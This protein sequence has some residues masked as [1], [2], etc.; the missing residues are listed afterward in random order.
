MI[1]YLALIT[2]IAISAISGYYSIVG[3]ATIF[4][5]AYWSV[6]MMGAALELGKLVTASWLYRNW[7]IAPSL[8]KIYLTCAV[9]LLMFI[10]SMGIFGFLSKAHMQ[11]SVGQN[12]NTDQ[13][14]II[15]QKIQFEKEKIDDSKKVLSQLDGAIDKLMSSDRLRGKDGAI[16][17]RNNQ[18]AEREQLMKDIEQSSSQ[19]QKFKLEVAEMS[20]AQRK[21]ELEVGPLKYIAELIYG[22]EAK[23]HFENAVRWVIILLVCV[24]DPLA[25]VLLVAANISLGYNRRMTVNKH[26]D[27]IEIDKKVLKT[28]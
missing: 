11:Q 25:V 2:A 8:L 23:N 24:F 22:E 13:I 1:N 4:S 14:E 18:K 27:T 10:T 9:I 19:I 3:L 12:D 15:Q 28:M 21:L 5:A 26:K 16:S 6:V 7:S 17:L 20:Q